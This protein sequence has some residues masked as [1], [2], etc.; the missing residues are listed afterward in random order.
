ML[1]KVYDFLKDKPVARKA[2]NILSSLFI[3]YIAFSFIFSNRA[4]VENIPYSEFLNMVENSGVTE[5][6]IK[7][8]EITAKAVND[9]KIYKVKKVEDPNLVDKLHKADVS[10]KQIDSDTHP[11]L[12]FFAYIFRI[13]APTLLILFVFSKI[14]KVD[15]LK[16]VFKK[17][18]EA[19][20]IK[21][22]DFSDVA[23]QEEAKEQLAEIISFLHEPEKYKTIGAKIPKGALLIGQPGTG[24]TLLAKAVAGEA[25]VPFLSISGSDFVELY[26]GMG[27]KRVREIFA[28][29]KRNAPCIIFIDE[30][31]SIAKARGGSLNSNNDEREQTLNQLLSEMD[32]FEPYSGIIVLAATNRPELLDR[33]FVRAGRFDRKITI[34]PPDIEE[35]LKILNVHTKDKALA[36]DV[37]LRKI[38]ESTSGAV[39]AD[40]ANIVN[41]A[42]IRAVKC[43]RTEINQEDFHYAFE[44][45]IAGAEKKNKILSEEE[46]RLVAY[47]ELGHALVAAIKMGSVPIQKIT[48]VPRTNGALGYT[49]QTPKE[50]EYLLSKERMLSEIMV[51]LGGRAAEDVKFNTITTGSSN[52]IE[53]ATDIIRKM[54]TVYGMSDEIGPVSLE[55]GSN[56]F[57]GGGLEGEMSSDLH[58]KIDQIIQGKLKSLYNETKNII[59]EN[60]KILDSLA[61]ILIKKETIT[62]DEFLE[63]L[64]SNKIN[65]DIV[66][67]VST[68]QNEKGSFENTNEDIKYSGLN[69]NDSEKHKAN[70]IKKSNSQDSSQNTKKTETPNN[71]QKQKSDNKNNHDNKT[72][73]S[74]GD[75]KKTR[76][77]KDECPSKKQNKE[78]KE[79]YSDKQTPDMK[80]D[81]KTVYNDN[82]HKKS[83]NRDTSYKTNQNNDSSNNQVSNKSEHH[84][85]A[86]NSQEVCPVES[87]SKKDIRNVD[88]VNTEKQGEHST[89]DTL[90]KNRASDTTDIGLK[91]T[92][93]QEES[94][95]NSGKYKAPKDENVNN[96]I[97]VS[98]NA[99]DINKPSAYN[100]NNDLVEEVD[101]RPTVS[102]KYSAAIKDIKEGI[103]NKNKK[104]NKSTISSKDKAAIKDMLNMGSKKNVDNAKNTSQNKTKTKKDNNDSNDLDKNNVGKNMHNSSENNKS[105]PINKEVKPEI[106]NKESESSAADAKANT[107]K[108]FKDSSTDIL[109]NNG[110]TKHHEEDTKNNTP[111]KDLGDKAHHAE[112]DTANIN[113]DKKIVKNTK[114]DTKCDIKETVAKTADDNKVDS[115][116]KSEAKVDILVEDPDEKNQN[117]SSE[118]TED[119]F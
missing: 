119:M 24:K 56:A 88:G 37:D 96:G 31:D 18:R 55:R 75:N 64:N 10:F 98:N 72:S 117:T 85:K 79:K 52:D 11:L 80:K 83:D 116:P 65:T 84:E 95:N 41:E 81:N 5:V 2:V 71:V 9:S 33:A 99:P 105:K 73:D 28:E 4:N 70:D 43:G 44:Y 93:I 74:I 53:K 107:D 51:L 42:A 38:A 32:G 12:S 20:E 102:N 46:I 114:T 50:D 91:I 90:T 69:N 101:K 113:S 30:V 118:I 59:S 110:D 77:V 87:N 45:T 112:P 109:N 89:E 39:G 40:I 104:G 115:K 23:G 8:K 76:P 61:D 108:K 35:R 27:A 60:I 17:N 19:E 7:D 57:L 47:H 21:E 78:I 14:M 58:G 111:N 103:K 106:V 34:N 86:T 1:K 22:I 15:T 49:L 6:E 16:F 100:K 68:T 67:I 54:I 29:A 36:A 13:F 66:N 82:L 97:D 3:G 63:I 25:K 94:S 62:G 26:A 92:D 48:I